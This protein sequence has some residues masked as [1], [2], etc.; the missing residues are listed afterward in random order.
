MNKTLAIL[1]I[2]LLAVFGTVARTNTTRRPL[3]PSAV[4]GQLNRVN[5]VDTAVYADRIVVSGYEK[6]VSD[7]N[8]SFFVT[9]NTP[10]HLSHLTLKFH[11]SYAD[12]GEMLHEEVYEVACDIPSGA[13]R[14]LLVRSFDR[15]HKLYYA[16]GRQPRRAATPFLLKYELLS[17]DV[18][19]TVGD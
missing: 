6:T 16:K 9:N 14:Q 11:Y 7:A 18:R 19:I 1:P 3:T 2:T 10:F 12:S 17:Y 13:T 8:E 4:V 15:Q 5:A